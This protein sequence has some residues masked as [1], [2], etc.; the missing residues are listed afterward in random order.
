MVEFPGGV[1][2]K[3]SICRICVETGLAPPQ[4]RH[5]SFIV[6]PNRFLHKVRHGGGRVHLGALS[7][8]A[9]RFFASSAPLL[10]VACMTPGSAAH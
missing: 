10:Q 1:Q 3:K 5:Q 4:T 2:R 9:A 6:D 7:S 8:V